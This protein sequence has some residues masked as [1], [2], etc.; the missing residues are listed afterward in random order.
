MAVE[1]NKDSPKVDGSR[2]NQT[3]SSSSTTNGAMSNPNTSAGP[4]SRTNNQQYLHQ[5]MISSNPSLLAQTHSG[6]NQLLYPN[7]LLDVSSMMNPM[8]IIPTVQQPSAA[9]V[10]TSNI[11]GPSLTQQSASGTVTN[12][13]NVN[14]QN[15]RSHFAPSQPSLPNQAP[16]ATTLGGVK[17]P[18]V[19]PNA[20]TAQQVQIAAAAAAA[21][22]APPKGYHGPARGVVRKNDQINIDDELGKPPMKRGKRNSTSAELTEEEKKQL[23]RDRNRQHARSTRLRKK[24][25]VNKLKELVDGLHAERSEEARKRRVAVQHLAE[26]QNIRRKV[27]SKFLHFHARYECDARKWDT[28]LENGFF[29]KQPLTPF[30]SFP[31]AEI[32]PSKEKVRCFLLVCVCMF[33]III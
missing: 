12:G 5:M 9:N 31:R 16:G 25:Y 30:R 26:V 22:A 17:I 7:P 28:I 4:P 27:I 24:A 10:T 32:E 13:N 23:N 19:P 29:L 8:R 14:F 15:D 33:F 18:P 21:E 3:V 1:N 6:H 11:S 2:S 20:S